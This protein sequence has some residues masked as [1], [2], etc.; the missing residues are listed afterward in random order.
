[1]TFYH[2]CTHVNHFFVIV[3]HFILYST[4][5]FYLKFSLVQFPFF[6]YCFDIAGGSLRIKT[7]IANDSF[8]VVVVHM[9]TK[10]LETS[11]Q[12]SL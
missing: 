5:I 11:K 10:V 8:S 2:D 9:T 3:L 7:F 12:L 6:T 1:M 4:P